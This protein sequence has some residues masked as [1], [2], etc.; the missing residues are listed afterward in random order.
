MTRASLTLSLARAAGGLVP[1][2]RPALADE[3]LLTAADM[4]CRDTG[5]LRLGAED[6][7]DATGS[8]SPLQAVLADLRG[9]CAREGSIYIGSPVTTARDCGF[10]GANFAGIL[11]DP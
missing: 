1:G 8:G 2:S 4:E 5:G 7:L 3:H 11:I 9:R 6:L 10:H